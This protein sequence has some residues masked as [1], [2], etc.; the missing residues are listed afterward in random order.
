MANPDI[1][2]QPGQQGGGTLTTNIP[3]APG[4]AAPTGEH[5][6]FDMNWLKQLAQQK[7]AQ[8]AN[9]RAQAR[10]RMDRML[11]EERVGRQEQQR[12]VPFSTK[13]TTPLDEEPETWVDGITGQPSQPWNPRAVRVGQN[14][15][16]GRGTQGGSAT[17]NDPGAGGPPDP[18]AGDNLRAD[19]TRDQNS[20]NTA[21]A[22]ADKDRFA[23]ADWERNEAARLQQSLA[24]RQRAELQQMS[25]QPPTA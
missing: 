20:L 15:K 1:L 14:R 9:D 22:A 4:F 12:R 21:D 5:V 3:Q 17:I 7:A 6:G 23:R 25:M 10:M 16:L 2:Y 18:T 13:A 24:A 19:A 11:R 8:E